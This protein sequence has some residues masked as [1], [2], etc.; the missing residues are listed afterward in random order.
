MLPNG[1]SVRIYQIWGLNKGR[2]FS[3]VVRASYVPTLLGELLQSHFTFNNEDAP[4]Y[5]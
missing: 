2:G 5:Y 4:W 3:Y 1:G